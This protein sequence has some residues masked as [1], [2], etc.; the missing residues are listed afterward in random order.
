MAIILVVVALVVH[1]WA[2]PVEGP[3]AEQTA[4]E[5]QSRGQ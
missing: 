4:V 2:G 3:V 5:V 1:T